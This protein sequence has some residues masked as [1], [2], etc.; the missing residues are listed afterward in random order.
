MR[1]RAEILEQQLAQEREQDE[2]ANR[3][4]KLEIVEDRQAVKVRS[5]DHVDF[6]SYRGFPWMLL[7]RCTKRA[8]AWAQFCFRL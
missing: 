3:M 8:D 1:A 6:I 4:K 2:Q 5:Y 7:L